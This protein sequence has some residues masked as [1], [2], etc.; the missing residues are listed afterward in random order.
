[1][2]IGRSGAADSLC[3]PSGSAQAAPFGVPTVAVLPFANVT[4]DPQY[5]PLT[6]RV[7][8][9]TRDAASSATLWR[10]VGRWGAGAAADPIEAGRQLNADYIVTGNLEAGADALRVTYQ[11]N[12]V[13]SG[14]RLWSQT[15]SP[16]LE[17]PTTTAAEAE[18]AGHAMS[19]LAFAVLNAEYA[20]LSSSGHI[21]KTA[22][23]C[24]L[25]GYFIWLKPETRG[26]ATASK[27]RRKVTRPT[28]MFG[29]PSPLSSMGRGPLAGASRPRRRA[30]KNASISGT[31]CCRRPYA[32]AI[33]RPWT[34]VLRLPSP[35]ATGPPVRRTGKKRRRSIPTTPP[36]WGP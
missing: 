16:V 6:H 24:V 30:S 33:S 15:I 14:A 4:G 8:Q 9:K 12:D 20:R 22:W 28:L 35:S 21:G 19:A 34:A 25:Q 36:C 18:V 31:G 26:L 7:G 11:L 5:D 3:G 23:G 17:K 10:I 32:P 29:R 13:H 1:V 27:R 2:N